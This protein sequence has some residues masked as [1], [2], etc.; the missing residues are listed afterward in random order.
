MLMP[1]PTRQ[2]HDG[3]IARY[4]RTGE[5]HIIGSGREVTG[6]HRDG[7]PIP[8]YLSVGAVAGADRPRFT[9]ILHDVS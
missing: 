6:L 1:E 4:L 2:A 3:Y 9:G 5:P 8:L 7:S